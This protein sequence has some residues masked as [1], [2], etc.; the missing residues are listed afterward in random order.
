MDGG[1]CSPPATQTLQNQPSSETMDTNTSHSPISEV[2][3]AAIV[4]S[5]NADTLQHTSAIDAPPAGDLQS[6][7]KR[8]RDRTEEEE[9]GE[10][11]DNMEKILRVDAS[12]EG[13]IN[14]QNVSA[15]SANLYAPTDKGPF[16]LFVE[17]KDRNVGRLHPMALGKLIRRE[18]ESLFKHV[19]NITAAGKNRVKIETVSGLTA[20]GLVQHPFLGKANLEAYIPKFFTTKQGIISDVETSLTE[21]ELLTE[22]TCCCE[23]I[24][25]RRFH[26]IINLNGEKITKPSPVCVVTFRS[27]RLPEFVY[28]HGVRCPVEVFVPSVLQCYNCLRFGHGSKQCR[29]TTRCA[30]CAGPHRSDA[31][32]RANQPSCLHCAGGHSALSR[33]CPAYLKHK[34]INRLMSLNNVTF[35]EAAA[36][37]ENRPYAT[38]VTSPPNIAR[39]ASEFPPLPTQQQHDATSRTA[40]YGPQQPNHAT[41]TVTQ[42]SALLA[43]VD[44]P[45]VP[46]PTPVV[47]HGQLHNQ[48]QA[49]SPARNGPHH[50]PIPRELLYQPENC[51]PL[52]PMGSNPYPPQYHRLNHPTDVGNYLVSHILNIIMA[53]MNDI[54]YQQATNGPTPVLPTDSIRMSIQNM[55]TPLL[56]PQNGL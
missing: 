42:T 17:S 56:T 50:I 3:S 31:C 6:S 25:I 51:L 48:Q 44:S 35:R 32:G 53:V 45:P 13:R 38:A 47:Q 21:D 37:F 46:P 16:I 23:V 43:P 54:S 49:N 9:H 11:R 20:N 33:T 26:K 22:M 1:D 28:I 36:V 4:A 14:H 34:E 39:Q 18:C 8:Q 29:S 52:S 30:Y 19:I 7:Q 2:I 12:P 10:Q 55:L 15:C 27:Q 41:T 24:A 5:H 40:T